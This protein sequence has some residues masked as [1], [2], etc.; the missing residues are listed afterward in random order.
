MNVDVM[1]Q[2]QAIWQAILLGLMAG[3][4]YDLFRIFRVRI[5]LPFLG[6]CLDFLFWI[7]WTVVLFL[8]SQWAWGGLVRLYGIALLFTGGVVYF[9]FL[10]RWLLWLGYRIADMITYFIH[11]LL[12]P[13]V[14][15]FALLKK[16]KKLAKNIFLSQ[17]K[18]YRINQ[19][20]REMEDT[21]SHWGKRGED[22]NEAQTGR[23]ADQSDHCSSI[24][25]FHNLF[26]GFRGKNSGHRAGDRGTA[27][28]GGAAEDSKST[29]TACHRKQ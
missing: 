2:V 17:R 3:L 8:W 20:T 5:P 13:V 28:A 19:I 18:W 11:I 1:A 4:C 15:F 23:D 27:G 26:A 21:A 12:L 25:L 6:G 16:I 7:G 22:S 29:A 24:D 14:L 10:S 9:C